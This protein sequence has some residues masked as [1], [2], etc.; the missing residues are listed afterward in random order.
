VSII[1]KSFILLDRKL[2]CI[3]GSTLP[4][5]ET[6]AEYITGPEILDY[7]DIRGVN[8]LYGFNIALL[9]VILIFFRSAA[10]ISLRFFNTKYFRQ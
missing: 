6:G 3:E 2:K 8:A 5:C 10:Y 1:N 4:V 9:I 7:L